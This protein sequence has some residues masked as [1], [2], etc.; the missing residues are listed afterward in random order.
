MSLEKTGGPASKISS[1]S[2]IIISEF[3]KYALSDWL[4][5]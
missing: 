1:H 5:I 3:N 4:I 2:E